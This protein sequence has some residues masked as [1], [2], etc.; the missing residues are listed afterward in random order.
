MSIVAEKSCLEISPPTTTR[1]SLLPAYTP[2]HSFVDIVHGYRNSHMT[3]I[4]RQFR[5]SRS[6]CGS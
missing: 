3:L 4:V 6:A 5:L 2:F 1:S